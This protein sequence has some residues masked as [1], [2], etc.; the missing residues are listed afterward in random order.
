[1]VSGE[2][3]KLADFGLA[4][5]LPQGSLLKEKSGTVTF[6]A[7]EQHRLPERSVG[8]GFPVD[9]WAA[10]ITL[11]MLICGGR[12]PFIDVHGCLNKKR[13]LA[14]SLTFGGFGD[15]IGFAAQQ[16]YFSE[17]ARNLCRSLV[18]VNPMR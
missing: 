4:A 17:K 13:L 6:M 10:G 2:A 12:H 11:H 8:Y 14:G 15:L 1:M 9:L 3:L 18:D 7:P 16:L 5:F